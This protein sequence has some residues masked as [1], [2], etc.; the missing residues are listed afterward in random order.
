MRNILYFLSLWV[1]VCIAAGCQNADKEGKQVM[2][3]EEMAQ[4]PTMITDSVSMLVSDSGIIRYHAQAPVW[5]SYDNDP[6]DKH[7]LFP[8]G[9]ELNQ[10]D[11]QKRSLSRIVADTAYYSDNK[12]LWHLTGNVRISN[13]RGEKFNT[14]ELYWDQR[15]HK[16]YSDS[17]IH[18]ERHADILEGYGFT[19]NEDFTNYLIRQTTGIFEMRS[20]GEAADFEGEAP[21]DGEHLA[22]NDEPGTLSPTV[23]EDTVTARPLTPK[24]KAAAARDRRNRIGSR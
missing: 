21:D 2:D 16:V 10:I 24:E 1:V 7:W 11:A 9:L 12:K 8:E 14:E 15:D 20:G 3:K 5:Y 23:D 19:S 6:M 18:I 4:I 22:E 17:F 13:V